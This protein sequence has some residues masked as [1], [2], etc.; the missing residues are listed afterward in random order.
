M[1]RAK[2]KKEKLSVNEI[3]KEKMKVGSRERKERE[4]RKDESE[5][6]WEKS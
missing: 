4:D 2:K 1:K 3:G 5:K 6:D